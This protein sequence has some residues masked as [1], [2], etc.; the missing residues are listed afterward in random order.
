MG[1]YGYVK[2]QMQYSSGANVIPIASLHYIMNFSGCTT[3]SNKKHLRW[4]HMQY[5]VY[6]ET[7]WYRKLTLSTIRCTL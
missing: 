6:L 2:F 1:N 3:V 5:H 7:S 4:L